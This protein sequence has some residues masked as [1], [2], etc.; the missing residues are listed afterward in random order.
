MTN[1][2]KKTVNVIRLIVFLA[3]VTLGGCSLFERPEMIPT[4]PETSTQPVRKHEI[5]I[6][7]VTYYWVYQ[8]NYPGH[9]HVVCPERDKAIIDGL[10]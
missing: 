1:L 10:E 6:D 2:K 3:I 8:K 9:G 5:I 7:G 4:E